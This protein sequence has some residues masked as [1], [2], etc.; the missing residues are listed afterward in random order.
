MKVTSSPQRRR[1]LEDTRSFGVA[2]ARA[3]QYSSDFDDLKSCESLYYEE[4]KS[5]DRNWKL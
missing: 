4:K 1:G 5:E 2:A 3:V